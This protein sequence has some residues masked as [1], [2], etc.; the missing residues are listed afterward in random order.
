MA[1]AKE[2]ERNGLVDGA[3]V[4]G[5]ATVAG[6]GTFAAGTHIAK[7]GIKFGDIKNTVVDFVKDGATAAKDA[8]Q[9]VTETAK[10]KLGEVTQS[11]TQ[12]KN[13]A[14][15]GI[16]TIDV[17]AV[18][19]VTSIVKYDATEA[20]KNAA[21]AAPEATQAAASS[22]QDKASGVF[23]G[24][25]D[26]VSGLKGNVEGL[27]NSFKNQKPC[28]QAAIIAATAVIA[29]TVGKV[30][31]DKLSEKHID[32]SRGDNVA[33]ISQGVARGQTSELAIPASSNQR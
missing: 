31:H 21:S 12:G 30:T 19:E 16:K 22:M 2:N 32:P 17:S 33:H 13:L 20:A 28:V 8:V 29:L 5:T 14:N 7:N 3:I 25:K 27:T 9:N 10:D 6:V 23:E 4:G 18:P 15:D 24:L 1:V 26:K 11:V